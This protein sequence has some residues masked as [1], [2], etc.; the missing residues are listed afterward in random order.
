MRSPRQ[1]R[2]DPD[3]WAADLSLGVLHSPAPLGPQTLKGGGLQ[4]AT[5]TL[6][7]LYWKR[8]RFPFF[9]AP[10][11]RYANV[12]EDADCL[13]RAFSPHKPGSRFLSIA[14]AGDNTLAL[15][16]LDP[17]EVVAI[18]CDPR[19]LA[20]LDLKIAAFRELDDNRWLQP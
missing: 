10:A 7:F 15:L 6:P 4:M 12:W 18:D 9:P 16:L 5:L 13:C 1:V 14:S 3:G 19:Q 8:V 11:I 20:C 17:S 2:D